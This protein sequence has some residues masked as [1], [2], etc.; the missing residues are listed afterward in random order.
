MIAGILNKH[1]QEPPAPR[2]G[3][4]QAIKQN[5]QMLKIK[6]EKIIITSTNKHTFDIS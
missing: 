4:A 5:K 2:L 1:S 6:T 3:L